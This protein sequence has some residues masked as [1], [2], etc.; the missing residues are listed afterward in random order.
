MWYQLSERYVQDKVGT[1]SQSNSDFNQLKIQV[2][3]K[4]LKCKNGQL[5]INGK[6]KN[7][8]IY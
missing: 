5:R 3:E 2:A 8:D 6:F 4:I 1:I 7:Y